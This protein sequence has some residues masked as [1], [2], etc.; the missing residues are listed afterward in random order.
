MKNVILLLL[1]CLVSSCVYEEDFNDD[2]E[3]ITVEVIIPADALR[4][5]DVDLDFFLH[6]TNQNHKF[7]GLK[8]EVDFEIPV[9]LDSEFDIPESNY[10]FYGYAEAIMQLNDRYDLIRGSSGKQ[11]LPTN[12]TINDTIFAI[13]GFE[14]EFDGEYLLFDKKTLNH[15]ELEED[16]YI[17]DWIYNPVQIIGNH[18]YY[19]TRNP[20]NQTSKIRYIDLENIDLEPQTF[21]SSTNPIL[22]FMISPQMDLYLWS[23]PNNIHYYVKNSSSEELQYM[24]FNNPINPHFI[25]SDGNF[26]AQSYW[27]SLQ[28]PIKSIRSIDI[29][30]DSIASQEVYNWGDDNLPFSYMGHSDIV[31]PNPIRNNDLIIS[32]GGGQGT[33]SIYEFNYS[34]G[35]VNPI[36]ITIGGFDSASHYLDQYVLIVDYSGDFFSPRLRKFNFSNF[37][38]VMDLEYTY[39][40]V[41]STLIN[42][43]NG[44]VY[45]FIASENANKIIEI[46]LNNTVKEIPL[47]YEQ[48]GMFSIIN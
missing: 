48:T 34:N 17:N 13:Q 36:D 35:S 42:K 28:R 12:I 18:M 11:L 5:E 38:E 2:V 19:I 45:S 43:N 24:D 47:N 26:Y 44:F 41:L 22:E 4:L 20:F 8:N 23:S 21:H 3:P 10:R 1:V 39:S 7:V 40:S 29:L 31:I 14:K 9:I 27:T 15:V 25:A 16:F 32:A 46:D 6:T 33:M 37:D 30:D